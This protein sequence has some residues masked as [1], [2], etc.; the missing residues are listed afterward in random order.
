MRATAIA[1]D[2]V[3]LV[4]ACAAAAVL[5]LPRA[6]ATAAILLTM[7]H[8][9]L[10]LVDHIHFQYNG[11]LL[12]VLLA[13]AAAAIVGA[14]AI[15]L[16]ALALLIC[17]KHLFIV[18]APPFAALALRDAWVAAA[19]TGRSSGG[20][21]VAAAAAV[22]VRPVAAAVA[23]VA[24][25]LA[26][27]LLTRHASVADQAAALLSRLFPFH[28]GLVHAYWAPNAWALYLAADKVV[29]AVVARVLPLSLRPTPATTTGAAVPTAMLPA[30]SPAVPLVLQAVAS[31]AVMVAVLRAPRAARVPAF[32]LS[33][34]AAYGV[35]FAGGWHV[36]EKAVLYVLVP[37]TF[38]AATDTSGGVAAI[39][40]AV[41]AP[42]LLSLWP[43]L[44]TPI[45]QPFV[46]AASCAYIAAVW[47]LWGPPRRRIDIVLTAAAL[48]VAGV[49]FTHTALLP[50]LPFAHLALVSVYAAVP[51][52]LAI[53]RL[54]CRL[55]AVTAR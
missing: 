17:L 8:A 15:A 2:A 33:L 54:A 52:L 30:I 50:T 51:I 29:A 47:A 25:C 21:R 5:R 43:L 27:V 13:A 42:A 9:G 23:V 26:P 49:Y 18:V 22:L 39:L 36:H 45:E 14:H 28:R 12:G 41:I 11:A 44:F 48:P 40:S 16:P 35:A 46:V 53:G 38:A 32:L 19:A 4:G 55:A 3:L 37:A 10:L 6:T 34:L 1:A 31:V 20:G 7:A 24:G